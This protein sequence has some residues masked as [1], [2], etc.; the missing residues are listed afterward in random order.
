MDSLECSKELCD[1]NL[2]LKGEVNDEGE[3]LKEF[4]LNLYKLS[5]EN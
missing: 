2:S 5:F 1:I 4:K 3:R